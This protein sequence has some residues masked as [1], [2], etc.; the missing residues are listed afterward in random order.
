[1]E[2]ALLQRRQSMDSPVLRPGTTSHATTGEA[3]ASEIIKDD[4]DDTALA[5]D[6]S[7]HRTDDN[8]NA[9]QK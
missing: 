4:K 1:M 7:V 5:P 9:K 3:L 2:I 8:Q 6:K